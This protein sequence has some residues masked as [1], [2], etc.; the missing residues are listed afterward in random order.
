MN[1]QF[2]KHLN[3]NPQSLIPT[4]I[5]DQL[6]RQQKESVGTTNPYVLVACAVSGGQWEQ[7]ASTCTHQGRVQF[8]GG[9]LRPGT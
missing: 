7:I 4:R 1:T 2:V 6:E 8:K 9:A 3:K 5:Q